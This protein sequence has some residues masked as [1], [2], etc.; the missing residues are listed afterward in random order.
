MMKIKRW[1]LVVLI[2]GLMACG[3]EEPAVEEGANLAEAEVEATEVAPTETAVPPTE[4][5]VPLTDTPVPTETP[6]PPTETPIPPTETPL[7]TETPVPPTDTPVPTETPIPPDPIVIGEE[8]AVDGCP[9]VELNPESWNPLYAAYNATSD[10][11]FHFHSID[12]VFYF[13]VEMYTAYGA[14][15]TGELGTFAPDCNGT[16]ICVYLVP[17]NINPYWATAGDIEIVELEQ[18]D[19][20]LSELVE[21]NMSNLTMMPVPGSQSTGCYHVEAVSILIGEEE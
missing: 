14:A 3:G 1:L 2:L 4:T 11:F 13:N 9:I 8:T 17:D 10:P 12:E 21:I 6:V 20:A 15:W 16:G 5:L 7:P 18:V 19:G